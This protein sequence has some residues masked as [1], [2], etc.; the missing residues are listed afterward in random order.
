MVAFCMADG[1][2]LLCEGRGLHRTGA[3]TAGH[4][5]SA[6]GIAFQGNFEASPLP[7]RL[8]TQLAALGDWLRRL[9]TKSGFVTLGCVRPRD[10]Q[11][12]GH[13]DVKQT[14]CPGEGLFERLHLIRFLEEDEETTMDKETWMKVQAALQAQEPPLY[15]ASVIDGIPG[16][17]TSTA[18]RAFERRLGLVSRGVMGELNDPAAGIWPATREL[19]FAAVFSRAE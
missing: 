6:L 16:S 1:E 2:L 9:R 13:R 10:R 5:R 3:H 15:A 12:W 7:S 18:V 11:V 4:N 17:N 14:V 8:D 19:L